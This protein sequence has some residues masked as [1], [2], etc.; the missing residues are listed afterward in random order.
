MP[1]FKKLRWLL[2]SPFLLAFDS[3][4]I[5]DNRF[6]PLFDPPRLSLDGTD[7]VFGA[8][9]MA[10]TASVAFSDRDEGKEV[11]IPEIYGTLDLIKLDNAL[12]IKG[13]VDETVR[14]DP[15]LRGGGGVPWH[16]NG[17]LQFQGISFWY[18]QGITDY[19]SAGATWYF[20]RANAHDNYQ[21]IDTNLILGTGDREELERKRR[22]IMDALGLCPGQWGDAGFGDIDAYFRL[23]KR[24]DYRARFRRIDVGLR[25]GMLAPTGVIRAE[26]R[27]PSVPFGGNGFWG[28]YTALDLLLEPKE[29]LKV[30]LLAR[31]SKRLPRET[32]RR[33]PVDCEPQIFGA[34]MAQVKIDP[35]LTSIVAPCVILENLRGGFGLALQYTLVYHLRDSWKCVSITDCA[36]KEALTPEKI[37]ENTC[38]VEKATKWGADYITL[39]AFY[40]FGRMKIFREFDPVVSLRW[41]IPRSMIVASRSAKTNRLSLGVEVAF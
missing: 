37:K 10:A 22:A 2:I 33:F 4:A 19:L 39:D 35:G 14:L 11:G 25:V 13:C 24:W 31:V 34:T 9:P 40:D 16:I 1:M 27:V 6:I 36:F 15:S 23:G 3:T 26:N 30:C 21:R 18:H 8:Y 38:N 28:V 5:Y 29:D 41:D 12:G 20:L 32:C 7:S 17:K